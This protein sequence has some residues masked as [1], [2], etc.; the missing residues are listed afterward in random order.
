MALPTPKIAQDIKKASETQPS[1]ANTKTALDS[2]TQP[3]A[4]GAMLPAFT[5][6]ANNAQYQSMNPY[7][8]VE[9]AIKKHA[10]DHIS[11]CECLCFKRTSETQG[12]R[13]AVDL[14]SVNA[15]KT[16]WPKAQHP[17]VVLVSLGAENLKQEAT[18][19]ASFMQQGYHVE[20]VLINHNFRGLSKKFQEIMTANSYISNFFGQYYDASET[21][22]QFEKLLTE[23]QNVYKT[24]AKV[25]GKF[26]SLEVYKSLLA[27]TPSPTI[28]ASYHFSDKMA[29]ATN[30][31]YAEEYQ[32]YGKACAD[33]IPHA[34]FLIDDVT[35]FDNPH[36]R[37]TARGMREFMADPS[38]R[39]FSETLYHEMVKRFCETLKNKA[40][41]L[42]LISTTKKPEGC[43][44]LVPCARLDISVVNVNNPT[45]STS[46]FAEN[47][48][49][50]TP[51]LNV[52]AKK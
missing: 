23:M 44:E 5:I 1:A 48:K 20:W 14:N 50:P 21:F 47:Y 24:T 3:N 26:S 35:E 19:T 17:T 12:I 39:N 31:I 30:A 22:V 51:N 8:F 34:L 33:K 15:F 32:K 40:K 11:E 4:S 10:L 7:Q 28:P 38:L 49:G 6:N 25:I 9:H 45:Q 27:N 13:N 41:Q 42:L 46:L 36:H 16:I 18:L 43:A 52:I 2:Q 29:A 37:L